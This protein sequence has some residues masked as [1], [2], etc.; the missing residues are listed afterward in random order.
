MPGPQVKDW[1][2]YH[3]LRRKGY[4]KEKAARIANSKRLSKGQ[5]DVN[6]VH[7]PTVGRK[8]KKKRKK[9]LLKHNAPTH[10]GTGTDQTVHDPGGGGGGGGD[11][12][13]AGSEGK[14]GDGAE[15]PPSL[16]AA[17]ELEPIEGE[18]SRRPKTL[19]DFIG[20]DFAKQ[21]LA[22]KIGAAKARGKAMDHVLLTGPK[23]TGKTTLAKII[24]NELGRNTKVVNA[25]SITKM[26]DLTGTLMQLQDGDVLF[27]DELHAMNKDLQEVLFPV[28]EDFEMDVKFGDD[29]VRVPI[30]NFTLV[31][32][33]TR[34]G[35]LLG[36]LQDRFGP[37]TQLNTYDI[38]DMETMV[39]RSASKMDVEFT[40][41]VVSLVAQRAKGTPR[42]ANRLLDNIQN[43]HLTGGSGGPVTVE[44]AKKAFRTWRIDHAGLSGD[45]REYL[46]VLREAGRPVGDRAIAARMETEAPNIANAIEPYL[47]AE[48]YVMRSGGGRVLT[49][50]G[51]AHLERLEKEGDEAFLDFITETKKHNAPTHPG[52][53]TDQGVHRPSS[54]PVSE[55]GG[56]QEGAQKSPPRSRTPEVGG[57]DDL[58][59]NEQINQADE[60]QP[61]RTG[62]DDNPEIIELAR[63]KRKEGTDL[64]N[65][66]GP[67][68]AEVAELTGGHTEGWEYRVKTERSL[69]KKISDDAAAD[70]ISFAEAA[71]KIND[72]TRYTVVWEADEQFRSRAD[73]VVAHMEEQGWSIFDKK[74]KNGMR[75]QADHYD[76]VNLQFTNGT[77]NFE[78]QFHTPGSHEKKMLAHPLMKE[79]KAPGTTPERQTEIINELDE[80]WSVRDHVPPGMEDWGVPVVHLLGKAIASDLMQQLEYWVYSVDGETADR[81][82]ALDKNVMPYEVARYDWQAGEWVN[83][84]NMTVWEVYGLGGSSDFTRVSDK[85]AIQLTRAGKG[86]RFGDLAS[87][88]QPVSFTADVEVAKSDDYKNLVFGWASV[89]F[90]PDGN[91]LIDKQGHAIDIEDLE[92]AAYNF[93]VN[94][95]ATG[96]M[97][98]SES[99]GELV[100]SMVLTAEK[101][102][103][104]GI[105]AG[106]TPQGWWV[107]FRVPPEYHQR[108]REGER[109][110]FSIEGT[111]KLE[112]LTS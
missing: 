27:L 73:Q 104:M 39:A 13:A 83:D 7:V 51:R 57:T 68:V 14:V 11:E 110:M 4:S 43:S 54:G 64:N 49:D 56:G 98:K 44:S 42:I 94:S 96:D 36:P 77:D 61:V 38:A 105:P 16:T 50:K 71:A 28:M 82:Y 103:L 85:L 41:E 55:G 22:D 31:G 46:S 102:E 37:P 87:E 33:T 99:F 29:I 74:Q 20:Q 97:H 9:K 88:D 40:P 107:G 34:P 78:L 95:Y 26:S 108:V 63:A 35:G 24:G 18:E 60:E 8:A 48:G 84:P 93:T 15:S 3:A 80:I 91:Q 52:T 58:A 10:P 21:Q 67:L 65:Q 86:T 72:H 111:A 45:Q 53:G 112:P 30:A 47:V 12:A 6:D 76:G 92:D 2:L 17:E 69:R 100:E 25:S 101:A 106:S 81:V 109:T 89:A 1:D 19:D 23:G 79:Y 90:T 70:G 75:L 5:P 62:I 32:A 66:V 59:D